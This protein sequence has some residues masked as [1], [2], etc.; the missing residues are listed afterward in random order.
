MKIILLWL[1]SIVC[2]NISH[3]DVQSNGIPNYNTWFK[4]KTI[5]RVLEDRDVMVDSE[6]VG[7][8]GF[9]FTSFMLTNSK[10]IYTQKK[11]RDYSIYKQ[12]SGA[13]KKFEYNANTKIIEMIGEASGFRMHSWIQVYDISPDHLAFKIFKGEMVGLTADIYTWELNSKTLM[14][15]KG[16]ITD[17][18]KIFPSALSL[19]AVPLSEMLLGIAS[20]NFRNHIE[21]EYKKK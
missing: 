3:A 12:M 17:A 6:W 9:E 14:A 21:E 4:P 8:N 18:K 20:K 15:L 1:L 16:T 19:I 2:F 13:I 5:Q 11:I 10:S 7:E